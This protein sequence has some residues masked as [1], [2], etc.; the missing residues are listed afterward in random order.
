MGRSQRWRA[1]ADNAGISGDIQCSIK[2]L[3]FPQIAHCATKVHNLWGERFSPHFGIEYM[4]KNITKINPIWLVLVVLLMFIGV[5]A[6]QSAEDTASP[7]VEEEEQDQPVQESP[8]NSESEPVVSSDEASS[9]SVE[10]EAEPPDIDGA[11]HSSPHANAFVVDADG[12]NNPCARCHAPVDWM[13]S[14]DDLPESCFVCKFELEEPPSYIQEEAWVSIPCQVCHE[15]DKKGE[16]QPEYSW[17]EIAAL[18][19]YASVVTPTEL[20]MKCHDVVNVPEHGIVQ[21]GGAH[22]GYECTECHDAHDTTASCGTSDCHEDVIEPVTPIAGHDDDH[23]D[24]SCVACHDAA[25]MEVG[26]SEALGY[27]ITFAPWTYEFSISETETNTET[28]IVAF[29]SHNLILDASCERCH[30]TDNPWGLS[31]NVD[32]P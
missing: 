32:G 4:K 8:D 25:G 22:E 21:V 11:W 30:F 23:R 10:V 1:Q 29:T 5:T 17:L 14:M 28:G 18:E 27:W 7:A 20:C 16:V 9:V 2:I 12:N 15:V 24:V 6:C 26:P 13:P 19:E 31:D 3:T